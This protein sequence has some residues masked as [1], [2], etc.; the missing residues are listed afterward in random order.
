MPGWRDEGSH[1]SRKRVPE[2]RLKRDA[3]QDLVRKL[4]VPILYQM[5]AFGAFE[6]FYD[7]LESIT[8]EASKTCQ[9]C[10]SNPCRGAKEFCLAAQA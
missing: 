5:P 10:G 4:F 1:N 6:D 9:V 3:S 8:C 7:F 2:K